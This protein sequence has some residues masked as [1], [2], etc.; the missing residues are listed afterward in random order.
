MSSDY[1]MNIASGLFSFA[2]FPN[3]Y[4]NYKNKNANAYNVIEKIVMLA[5]TGFALGYSLETDSEAF[6][7]NYSIIFALDTIALFMRGYYAYKNRN[8][9]VTV[10]LYDNA[11]EIHNPVSCGL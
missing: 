10:N 5:G 1:L 9:D 7:I 3:L 6:K 11:D 4:A 2:I 8:I